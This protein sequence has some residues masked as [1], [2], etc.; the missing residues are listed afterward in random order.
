MCS[1]ENYFIVINNKEKMEERSW[2]SKLV[3]VVK[4]KESTIPAVQ[5]NLMSRYGLK[6]TSFE[7]VVK[8]EIKK[9]QE[10]IYSKLEFGSSERIINVLVPGDQKELFERVRQHFCDKGYKSFYIDK[11][12]VKELGN[13]TF[14]FISWD[15]S[16]EELM[17]IAMEKEATEDLGG[18]M[19]KE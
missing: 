12:K 19:V 8:D 4:R 16:E 9:I 3:S 2:F 14:L 1:N 17:K 18:L 10:I 15:L 7:S 6:A 13:N 5:A 11:S